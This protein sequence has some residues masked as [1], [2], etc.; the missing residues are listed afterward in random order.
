M[1]SNSPKRTMSNPPTHTP[2]GKANEGEY[3]PEH[4]QIL[5]NAIAAVQDSAAF[6]NWLRFRSTFHKYSLWNTLMIAMQC[7]DATY[8]AGYGDW[9][10]KHKRQ[11]MKGEKSIVILA[12]VMKRFTV[13]DAQTGDEKV[14][15]R[16]T[17]YRGARVFDVSQTEGEALPASPVLAALTGDSHAHLLPILTTHAESLGYAVEFGPIPGQTQGFCNYTKKLIAVDDS[18]APNA[19]VRILVHELIHAH[20][21]STQG[22]GRQLA[23][24]ITD[25]AAFVACRSL[26]LDVLDVVSEYLVGWSDRDI[27]ARALGY[28]DFYAAHIERACGV[29]E[30]KVSEPKALDVEP[31]SPAGDFTNAIAA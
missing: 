3:L 31:E 10:K 15:R 6:Q 29:H 1:P 12:P 19:Q 21:A 24:T 25:S 22:F 27:R 8:V 23:E 17:G 7:P 20:G 14:V 30:R 16:P 4:L 18:H 28:I 2:A 26:G 11:V 13:E 5:E 9:Q